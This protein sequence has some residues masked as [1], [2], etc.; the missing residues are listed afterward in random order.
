MSSDGAA[1]VT[2]KPLLTVN[3]LVKQFPIQSTA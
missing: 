1:P 2:T 3:G